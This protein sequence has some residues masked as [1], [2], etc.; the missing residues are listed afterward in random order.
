VIRFCTTCGGP[1]KT[2][3]YD[4]ETLRKL[5]QI[6]CYFQCILPFDRVTLRR[7][8]KALKNSTSTT[9]ALGK[10]SARSSTA[11]GDWKADGQSKVVIKVN[12]YSELNESISFLYVDHMVSHC[13]VWKGIS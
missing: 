11:V 9:K 1:V 8:G 4:I 5:I 2:E 10:S 3:R 12:R 7:P 6:T 13:S